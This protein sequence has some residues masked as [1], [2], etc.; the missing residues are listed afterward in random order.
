MSACRDN[1]TIMA[2]KKN[3]KNVNAIYEKFTQHTP[4]IAARR[5]HRICR[6]FAVCQH[7]VI[8]LQ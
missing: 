4:T 1:G 7:I 3:T 8:D 2:C 6:A 5:Q